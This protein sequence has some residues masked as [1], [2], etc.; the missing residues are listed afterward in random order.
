MF[1]FLK[2]L[3]LDDKARKALKRAP[4]MPIKTATS[5][6]AAP[7]A[8]RPSPPKAPA[9]ATPSPNAATP[10]RRELIAN[11]MAVH[12][13]KQKILADLSD[14]DRAKLIAMAIVSFLNEGSDP[15]QSR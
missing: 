7:V 6:K 15:D 10:Q 13:A 5:V 9:K 11:A 3:F 8:K 14:E 2:T 4:A 1:S 12:R